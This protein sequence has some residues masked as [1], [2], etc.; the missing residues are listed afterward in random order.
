MQSGVR[1]ALGRWDSGAPAGGFTLIELLVVI[2][3]IAILLGLLLPAVQRIREAAARL[4][5]QNNLKQIGLALHSHADSMGTLPPGTSVTSRFSYSY[6]Y[7]WVYLLHYLFPYLEQESIYRDLG[8]PQF[9]TL[10]NPWATPGPWPA[11]VNKIEMKMLLCP[12]DGRGEK[13]ATMQLANSGAPNGLHLSRTNYIG[14]FSGLN[15]GDSLAIPVASQRAVFRYATGTSLYVLG[16]LVSA[17]AL[18]RI[19]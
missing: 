2:A 6:P 9:T 19:A 17:I 5:C 10:P 8:G 11:S 1:G 15:D 18:G 12:S 3:I 7:E 14:F 13:M 4:Q 16:M